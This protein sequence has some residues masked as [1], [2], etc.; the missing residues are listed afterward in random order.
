MK[1][2]KATLFLLV[3]V[4]Q[5]FWVQSVHSQGTDLQDYVVT[6]FGMEEGLPQNSVN[7]IIQTRDGYIWL[8]T[9]GGLV[10]FDGNSFTNF[11][12]ANTPGMISDRIMGLFEA[13]DGA[14]WLY[15]E[16]GDTRL[17]RFKD[18][19]AAEYTF[20]E[21][22]ATI[23]NLHNDNRGGL[24]ATA[25]E[26][27]YRF[28]NN[29]F[30]EIPINNDRNLKESALSDSLGVWIS[31]GNKVIKTYGDLPVQMEDFNALISS[32][33][34]SI[35]EYPK[36]S[37]EV[38]VGTRSDG[39][40]QMMGNGSHQIIAP[41]DFNGGIFYKFEENTQKGLYAHLYEK[42]I[43]WN[44][45]GFEE[46][47]P[48][49]N[50]EEEYPKSF[51]E[52]TEGNLWVGTEGSGLYK[53]RPK[54]ISMI[55]REKGLRNEK[56]LSLE[57]VNDDSA[58]LSTNCDGLYLWKNNRATK[59]GL[60]EFY[61]GGC[62]WSV[63]Q[64]SKGRFWVGENGV[65]LTNSLSEEGKRFGAAEGFSNATVFA[66][67]EDKQGNIWVASSD[68][69]GV[70]DGEEFVK[71]YTENDGLYYPDARVLTEDNQGK[72]WVGSHDG[73]N[74]I[75]NDQVSKVELL[76]ATQ[77]DTEVAQPYV[78]AIYQDEDGTMW[79]GTYGNGL[80]RIKDGQ[81]RQLTTES[82]LFD[83]VVSHIIEDEQGFFWMGS[84]RGI[85][86]VSR[87]NLNSYLDGT[88]QQIVVKVFGIGEGMNSAETNG[89][90]QPSAVKD[91]Q[92]RIYFPTVEG[93]AVVSPEKV[94]LNSVPP[95]VYIENLRTEE[96]ELAFS[97]TVTLSHD[98][99]FLE[100]KYTALSFTDPKKVEFKYKL[101]GLDN[102][103][104]EVGSR[105]EALYSRIPAGTYTFK[106]IASN[107]DGVWNNEGAS[108][109]LVVVP[110]FYMSTWFF[111][112]LG[113]VVITIGPAIYYYRI[114]QLRKE[115]ERHKK[116]TEQLIDS[117]EHE[118]RRIAAELHDGLGQQI[119]VIKNRAE[120]AKQQSGNPD[121]LVEQLEEIMQSAV[122]SI[123]DV[124][125]ISHGLRPVHLEKFGL[126]EAIINLC[127]E[128][129]ETSLIDWRYEIDDIDETIPKEKEINF[130]R[131]LQEGV[132]N[133]LKHSNA[134]KA[135]IIIQKKESEIQAAL[136][137]DGVGFDTKEKLSFGG[138]GLSG[139]HERVE[140]LGG[141]IAVQSEKENGTTIIITIPIKEW[142]ELL[143]P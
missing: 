139:M 89:G 110:P 14:I 115:H 120:L 49:S 71:F 18:G 6:Q 85:A 135:S 143:K 21:S 116:F 13:V 66:A 67:T 38:F 76:Q 107:E 126:T 46:F 10:R 138:M 29:S 129:Q 108:F 28:T 101:E 43:K 81:I 48:I 8:A 103:W 111:V 132:K 15:I 119:L 125:S 65:I 109:Q 59:E 34:N 130:Y 2:K 100:I 17:V 45:D 16:S 60:H 142:A 56:M 22:G 87:T 5:I 26:K 99:G 52:D 33:V 131:V 104:I 32:S 88:S 140:T 113:L 39:I 35:I 25:F 127:E 80:F 90:F 75:Y 12:R 68:G 7:D 61:K 92:G 72:M 20:G 42:M 137:D 63:F 118:R 97:E 123:S 93:V 122:I 62:Y 37:G 40:I 55:D 24:W 70:F 73:L 74:T 4:L 114:Q 51:L 134:D 98:T 58:V 82:G 84:N 64:D 9:Y 94:Q 91:S 83:D 19:K 79:I 50:F 53:L 133:I 57:I 86:R 112:L 3:L 106:V 27:V 78:R 102:S 95:P 54:P 69:L 11:S 128:V 77:V 136:K 47:N 41:E 44:G 121:Q 31:T 124:R 117:Q 105:R 23:L 141:T 30:V 96:S 36:G 1:G